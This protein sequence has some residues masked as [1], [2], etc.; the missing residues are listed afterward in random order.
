MP[1]SPCG[2]DYIAT[3]LRKRMGAEV[4]FSYEAGRTPLIEP[5][6]T[7]RTATTIWL[8]D[9]GPARTISNGCTHEI[10]PSTWIETVPAALHRPGDQGNL[11]DPPLR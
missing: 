7:P 6:I 5:T 4:L 2:H 1:T 8:M 10:G 9:T 11:A 3:L